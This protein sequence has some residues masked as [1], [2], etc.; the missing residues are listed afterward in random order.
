MMC[1][2]KDGDDKGQIYAVKVLV[3]SVIAAKKQVCACAGARACV[4]CARSCWCA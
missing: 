3:K 1:R 4:V 2:K